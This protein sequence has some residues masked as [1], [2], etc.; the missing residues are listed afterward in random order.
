MRVYMLES[1]Q[2]LRLLPQKRGV[3]EFLMI[4]AMQIQRQNMEAPAGG[5]ESCTITSDGQRYNQ[6]QLKRATNNKE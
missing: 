1:H 2:W 5:S 6:L 3:A 4:W